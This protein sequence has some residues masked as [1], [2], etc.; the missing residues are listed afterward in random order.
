[1]STVVKFKV[2][3]PQR[4]KEKDMRLA[5]LNGLRAAAKAVEK[6]YKATT[7]TWETPVEFETIISLR[8]SR[9]EFLVGTSSKIYEYVDKGTRPHVILPKRAKMLR[10]QGGYRAKTTPGVIGSTAGGASGNIVYSRGVMHPGTK[11]R[12][13]SELINKKNESKFKDE[14]HKAMR[15]AAEKSGHKI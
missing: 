1:M 7:A 3:K 11:A 2:L 6:D 5:L 13:F 8:G 4:L 15:V 12:R 14:M 10:F 9:A